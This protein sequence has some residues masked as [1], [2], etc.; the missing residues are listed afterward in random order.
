M[1]RVRMKLMET[2]VLIVAAMMMV[3]ISAL[4]LFMAVMVKG[5]DGVAPPRVYEKEKK[6]TLCLAR[7]QFV[8]FPFACA[9]HALH[10][11]ACFCM[12]FRV[13]GPRWQGPI[14]KEQSQQRSR[15]CADSD[16]APPSYPHL[17]VPHVRGDQV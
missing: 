15:S 17:A 9:T 16:A 13:M 10:I 7:Q 8:S 4:L 3:V 2:V 6:P 5:D 11:A 1:F 12:L 14:W